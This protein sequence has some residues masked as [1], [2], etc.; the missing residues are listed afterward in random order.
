MWGRGSVGGGAEREGPTTDQGSDKKRIEENDGR[1]AGRQASESRA[2]GGREKG[3][4]GIREAETK[5][6]QRSNGAASEQATEQRAMSNQHQGLFGQVRHAATCSVESSWQKTEG[7]DG[8]SEG[9][10]G[11]EYGFPMLPSS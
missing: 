1:Q 5:H 8:A 7:R 2:G 3:R 9:G 11:I 4:E 6:E 10:A